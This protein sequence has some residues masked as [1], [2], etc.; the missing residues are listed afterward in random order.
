[1]K[2]DPIEHR[3]AAE[4]AAIAVR[5]YQ[6]GDRTAWERF[7]AHCP[8]AT[9][10]HR[11][12]WRSVLEN[13]LRHRA[14]Y[15]LAMRG[16]EIAGVLPLAEVKS[17]LFGHALVSLPFAA[18]AGVP[19]WTRRPRMRCTASGELAPEL[20]ADHLELRNRS[21]ASRLAAPRPVTSF[22]EIGLT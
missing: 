5:P 9:F 18:S 13:V 3:A 14:H 6:A 1:V 22:R 21:R 16:A 20:D 17:R 10:F 8:D 2:H 11:I 7:V 15:L 19:R 12:G 4:R